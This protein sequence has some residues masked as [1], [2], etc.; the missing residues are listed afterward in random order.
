MEHSLDK[1]LESARLGKDEVDCFDF[2]SCFP[3]VPKLACKHMGLDIKNPSKPITLLGGLTS[4]GGAG[5][6]Y[7]LHAIVQMA[8]TMR[9]G[10]YKHGLVLANGGVLSWQHAL[11]L[12]TQPRRDLVPYSRQEVLEMAETFPGPEFA[13]KAQGEAVIESYTVD[14]DRTGPKLGHIVGRLLENGHRFI[15]NHGDETTLSTLASNK[16]EP[17]GLQGLVLM[18]PGGR[19]LFSIKPSVKL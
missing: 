16:V 3:I 8:R 7:S 12:S 19:N 11:C 15:A 6:N 2:Y 18:A 4:F 5:N 17:I 10:A 1:A 13:Q 14:F 9:S